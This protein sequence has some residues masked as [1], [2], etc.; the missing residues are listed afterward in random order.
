MLTHYKD[1]Y[2]G[3]YIDRDVETFTLSR[4][5]PWDSLEWFDIWRSSLNML[6]IQ[7]SPVILPTFSEMTTEQIRLEG[8]ILYPYQSYWVMIDSGLTLPSW[9]D[10]NNINEYIDPVE[11]QLPANDLE[12]QSHWY[13]SGQDLTLLANKLNID[14]RFDGLSLPAF[15]IKVVTTGETQGLLIGKNLYLVDGGWQ[16]AVAVKGVVREQV[17]A[18][19]SGQVECAAIPLS[20]N[21]GSCELLCLFVE[22]EIPY[23]AVA[24]VDI[25]TGKDGVSELKRV[26]KE[27]N[28]GSKPY[29]SSMSPLTYY[30]HSRYTSGS[31]KNILSNLDS[32]YISA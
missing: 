24:G 27:V 29:I 26:I 8:Y 2:Y 21:N 7:K 28:A 32:L 20:L 11:K 14:T 23:A 13:L 30:H 3:L 15:S 16:D 4:N 9:I 18:Y 25:G 31:E 22:D 10:V 12:W 19:T 6:S 5:C 1:K 17:H